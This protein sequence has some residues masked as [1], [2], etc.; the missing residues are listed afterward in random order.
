MQFNMKKITFGI[1]L[2]GAGA[3][4]ENNSTERAPADPNITHQELTEVALT[5]KVVYGVG[6]D[7][8]TTEDYDPRRI[9]VILKVDEKVWYDTTRIELT[10]GDTP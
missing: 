9:V 1:V 3:C 5:D 2:L 6:L 8:T 4:T 10:R 7:L